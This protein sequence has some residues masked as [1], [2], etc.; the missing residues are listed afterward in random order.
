MPAPVDHVHRGAVVDEVG[1]PEYQIVVQNIKPLVEAAA[2][3]AGQ[4]VGAAIAGQHGKRAR[5]QLVANVVDA[6]V[7]QVKVGAKA[8]PG[9]AAA[10]QLEQRDEDERKEGDTGGQLRQA[11]Q[12]ARRVRPR[13]KHGRGSEEADSLQ[14]R[15]VRHVPAEVRGQGLIRPRWWLH[16]L[17]KRAK[18]HVK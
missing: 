13:V 6:V 7:A 16:F 5:R 2:V 17:C 11:G 8:A 10:E 18:I 15:H 3:T 14:I 9:A 12:P 1:Q 4:H